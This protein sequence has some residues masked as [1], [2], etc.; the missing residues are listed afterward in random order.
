M[1]YLFV[2]ALCLLC[3]HLNAQI[4]YREMRHPGVREIHTRYYSGSGGRGYTSEERLD[5]Q[6]RVVN[7][8]SLRKNK[9]LAEYTYAYSPHHDLTEEITVFDINRPEAPT[10][11]TT[12]AYNYA[13]DGTIIRKETRTQAGDRTVIELTRQEGNSLRHYR[14]THTRPAGSSPTPEDHL[15]VYDEEGRIE[16]WE[17]W[18]P[19]PDGEERHTIVRYRYNDRD[20][21]VHRHIERDP[22][23]PEPAV[24]VGG[25]GS[26]DQ[27]YSYRYDRRGRVKVKF[28]TVAGRRYKLARYRYRTY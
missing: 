6:G 23:Y 19:D 14:R 2:L 7:K 25:P 28:T 9:L 10:T 8:K 5:P 26:D 11:A 27:S 16:R 20:L 17:N 15:L 24:Y 18:Q 22:P 1:P 13:T 12:H 21:L 4:L 3:Q